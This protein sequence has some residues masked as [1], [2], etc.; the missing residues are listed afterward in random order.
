M[1]LIVILQFSTLIT[2]KSMSEIKLTLNFQIKHN[3]IFSRCCLVT[4]LKF[5]KV[6]HVLENQ[7]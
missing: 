4:N 3:L 1:V 2:Y 6:L 5:N 7:P